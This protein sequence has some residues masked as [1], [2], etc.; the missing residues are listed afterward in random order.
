MESMELPLIWCE[1][2]HEPLRKVTTNKALACGEQ[3]GQGK[4]PASNSS[5]HLVAS[6]DRRTNFS[7]SQTKVVDGVLLLLDTAESCT[8]EMCS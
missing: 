1:D 7:D 6:V 4:I 5:W 2:C 8:A 3:V